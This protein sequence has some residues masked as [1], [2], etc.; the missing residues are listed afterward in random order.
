MKLQR[1]KKNVLAYEPSALGLVLEFPLV[2]PRWS[3]SYHR[4]TTKHTAVS[5]AVSYSGGAIAVILVLLKV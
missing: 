2:L 3:F 1:K 4:V 5:I